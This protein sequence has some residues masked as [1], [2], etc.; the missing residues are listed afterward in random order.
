MEAWDKLDLERRKAQQVEDRRA[1]R[2]FHRAADL[3]GAPLAI[4][5]IASVTASVGAA[6]AVESAAPQPAMM[7][8]RSRGAELLAQRLANKARAYSLDRMRDG[9]FARLAKEN[10]IV[11]SQGGR[12]DDVTVIVARVSRNEATDRLLLPVQPTLHV[13]GTGLA[14][15]PAPSTRSPPP[16]LAPTNG[17]VTVELR[18]LQ[19][20]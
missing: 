13:A 12:P 18:R 6:A 1:G 3:G 4:T 9:P 17:A 20:V 16:Q 19:G 10:D 14:A 2:V 11:W 7:D 15:T 5:E 8:G